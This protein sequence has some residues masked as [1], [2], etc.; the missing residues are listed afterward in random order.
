MLYDAPVALVI[1]SDKGEGFT[2]NKGSLELLKSVD[3]Q[4]HKFE[5][6]YFGETTE[7]CDIEQELKIVSEFQPEDHFTNERHRVTKTTQVI[8]EKIDEKDKQ[9]NIELQYIP[10]Q[11]EVQYASR[12]PDVQYTPTKPDVQ[13][14]PTKPDVQYT[15]T[16]PDVQYTPTEPEVQ[17]NL[18]EP[19]VQYNLTEP[20]VQYYPQDS[21]VQYTPTEP[22]VQYFPN[23]S[24]LQYY[25]REPEVQYTPSLPGMQYTPYTQYDPNQYDVQYVPNQPELQSPPFYNTD[26][27]YYNNYTN[28]QLG[29]MNEDSQFNEEYG[30]IDNGIDA[31]DEEYDSDIDFSSYKPDVLYNSTTSEPEVYTVKNKPKKEETLNKNYYDVKIYRKGDLTHDLKKSGILIRI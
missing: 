8:K 20:E 15:P 7:M 22:E 4:L 28:Y 18:T 16:K 9:N 19:E 26:A 12:E 30:D 17:Y 29:V 24:K 5:K 11:P 2:T 23:E 13:Y 10:K 1:Y 27:Q 25:S 14:T 3:R 31:V 6:Q 21:E